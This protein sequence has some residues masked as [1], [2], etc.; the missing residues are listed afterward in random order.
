MSHWTTCITLGHQCHTGA[1][2]PHWTTS[3]TLVHQCHTGPPMSYWTTCVILD[4]Q[5]HTEPPIEINDVMKLFV[6]LQTTQCVSD[7]GMTVQLLLIKH[8]RKIIGKIFTIVIIELHC[9]HLSCS[10]CLVPHKKDIGKQC[11]PR[12]DCRMWHLIRVYTV[13]FN[14]GISTKPGPSCSKRR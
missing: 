3:V 6:L 7:F 12:S 8:G 11:R 5:C 2:M 1:P 4:H 10:L 14:T 9:Y 13:C